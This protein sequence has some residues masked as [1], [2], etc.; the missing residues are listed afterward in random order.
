MGESRAERADSGG[1]RL[2]R[3]REILLG[4]A[5]FGGEEIKEEF[6]GGLCSASVGAGAF[7]GNDGE[8]ASASLFHNRRLPLWF[9]FLPSSR[10]VPFLCYASCCG[11]SLGFVNMGPNNFPTA[12]QV[13]IRSFGKIF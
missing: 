8:V 11:L 7:A 6:G 13:M 1:R 3:K 12:I 10:S 4:L 5:W 2:K 9:G